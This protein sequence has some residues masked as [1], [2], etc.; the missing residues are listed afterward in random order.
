MD[1]GRG[2]CQ[3]SEN[4]LHDAAMVSSHHLPL[5]KI[6]SEHKLSWNCNVSCKLQV[7]VT[8]PRGSS[9]LTREPHWWGCWSWGSLC[10]SGEE[11][12]THCS[13]RYLQSPGTGCSALPGAQELISIHKTCSY[14][15][16]AKSH[17]VSKE[18][19]KNWSS[20]LGPRSL[21]DVRSKPCS[22]LTC[23]GITAFS[24]A[25]PISAHPASSSPHYPSHYH[26]TLKVRKLMSAATTE[27]YLSAGEIN[28]FFA[29][30]WAPE[31][32]SPNLT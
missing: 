15:L 24:K 32:K 19:A 4:M 9:V 21:T 18:N 5:A 22:G 26:N 7:V 6:Q 20:L 25:L 3:S 31:V 17:I 23:T 16:S 1:S 10:M 12:G 2:V 8:C 11:Q 30:T 13:K 14:F 29:P 28:K 27:E